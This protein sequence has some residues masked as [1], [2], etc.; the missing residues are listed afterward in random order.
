MSTFIQRNDYLA[1]KRDHTLDQLID[2]N[3]SLL[4]QAELTAISEVKM[5]LFTHYNIEDAFAKTGANRNPLLVK[6]CINVSLYELYKRIP[7]EAVPDRIIKDYDD[8]I[9]TLTK[10]AAGDIGLELARKVDEENE[11]STP[12]SWR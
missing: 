12:L 11:N 7:D 4:D 8:T 9:K 6:W 1:T 5:Y 10:V 2:A 3:D